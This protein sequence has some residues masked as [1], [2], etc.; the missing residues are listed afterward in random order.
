MYA[1]S[2]RRHREKLREANRWEW[3][4]FFDHMAQQHRALSEDYERRALALVE[5]VS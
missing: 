1:E 4:R 5:E 3:V 2:T